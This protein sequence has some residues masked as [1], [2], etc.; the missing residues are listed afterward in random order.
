[1][2]QEE[3]LDAVHARHGTSTRKSLKQ[4]A[5]VSSVLKTFAQRTTKFLQL[6]S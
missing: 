1:V 5:Q 2:L 6:S 4:L 3:K